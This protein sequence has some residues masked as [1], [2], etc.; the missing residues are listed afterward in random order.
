M[1]FN[2]SFINFKNNYVGFDCRFFT[3]EFTPL[4]WSKFSLI[5]FYVK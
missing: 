5:G 3:I 1:Y 4:D 2:I